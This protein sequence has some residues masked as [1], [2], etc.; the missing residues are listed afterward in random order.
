MHTIKMAMTTRGQAQHIINQLKHSP[1]AHAFDTCKM[2]SADLAELASRLASH[3]T[4]P[5]I[6]SRDAVHEVMYDIAR[7]IAIVRAE[8]GIS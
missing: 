2:L 8:L 6:E 3:L 1:T 7:T 5:C 4:C